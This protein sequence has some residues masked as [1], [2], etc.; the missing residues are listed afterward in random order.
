MKFY[1]ALVFWLLS[2][3]LFATAHTW[4]EVS[5][6]DESGAWSCQ[7][8]DV[9]EAGFYFVDQNKERI[10]KF[11][12]SP[13]APFKFGMVL[14]KLDNFNMKYTLAC[15]RDDNK[16]AG[17]SQ[18][19]FIIGAKG[20]ADPDI[21]IEEYAGAKGSWETNPGVGENYS[22]CLS[23][24][25]EASL[26]EEGFDPEKV[27]IQTYSFLCAPAYHFLNVPSQQGLISANSAVVR[28]LKKLK[29]IAV[30]EGLRIGFDKRA[31]THYLSSNKRGDLKKVFSL[32]KKAKAVT[33]ATVV[34]SEEG[35]K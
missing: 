1:L 16:F 19:V 23:S 6:S 33:Y 25:K 26:I 18:V 35:G 28:H 9:V 30:K 21:R 10:E 22:V 27:R 7:L 12:I 29:K 24:L 32:R 14:S 4:H 17:S 13:T 31:L 3:A 15:T 8:A 5:V 11:S 2:S 20:P 34:C